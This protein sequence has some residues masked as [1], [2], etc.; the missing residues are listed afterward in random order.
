[1][2]ADFRPGTKLRLKLRLEDF[3]IDP[4]PASWFTGQNGVEAF[5]AGG[6]QDVTPNDYITI[7]DIEPYDWTVELN[8]PRRADTAKVTF[9]RSKL[10]IDPQIIRSAG[11]QIFCGVFTP[12]EYAEACGGPGS[13]GLRIP[14]IVPAGRPFA[15][16]SNELFRGFIDEWTVKLGREGNVVEL[17]AR[18]TTG[19]FIDAEIYENPLRHLPADMPI[20][21]IIYGMLSGDGLP[22]DITRRGGLAGAR[23]TAVVVETT[24]PIPTLAQIKPPNWYGPK[25]TVKRP[26]K[27]AEKAKPMKFWDFITDLVVSAG[28]KAYIRPGKK[29]VFDPGLGYVLPAAEIV[30]CDAQTYYAKKPGALDET[31]MFS[32][33]RNTEEIMCRRVLGGVPLPTIEVRSFDR[34]TGSQIRAKYPPNA[35]SRVNKATPSGVGDREEVRVYE[36]SELS[37]PNAQEQAEAAARSF[38]DQLARGEFTVQIRTKALAAI[39]GNEEDGLAPD[40]LYLRPGEP[41]RVVTDPARDEYGQVSTEGSFAAMT[42][43]EFAA[44]IQAA[45]GIPAGAAKK[46]AR[47]QYDP[48]VQKVFYTQT[49]AIA[50]NHKTGLEFNV[51]AINYLDAR[52]AISDPQGNEQ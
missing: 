7:F 35:F 19:F 49:N 24:R 12:A 26:K 33:G 38:Y 32:A 39:P 22:P 27:K 6:L 51:T 34:R 36:I 44:T 29:P 18:D 45:A 1:M 21:Q 8:S 47:A 48:R 23:G 2:V 3:G 43:A 30:I 16:E 50:Y 31:P 4:P 15:G 46:I 25:R 13:K 20:D 11:L 28:L 41:I 9:P 14:D 42:E 40:M 37:G 5:G 17:V 52:G 10:P